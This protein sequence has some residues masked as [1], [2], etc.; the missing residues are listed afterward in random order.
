MRSW[1]RVVATI[2]DIITGA[3]QRYGVDPQALVRIAE[4]ESSLN[5]GARNPNSSAGGLFQ[6]IDS[7]AGQ[8]GLADRFD[9]AQAADAAARLARDNAA[10]L[11]SVLGRD[12]SGAEL[13]LAHQQ[14]LG[15]A[16]KILGNPD[17][18]LASLVGGAAANLNAGAGLTAGQFAQNWASKFGGGSNGTPPSAPG[19]EAGA[20]PGAPAPVAAP[21]PFDPSLLAA[22]FA[23]M[24]APNRQQPDPRHAEQE[25]RRRALLSTIGEMYA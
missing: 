5:P 23:P 19:A 17:A 9:P 15:G 2:A 7:T 4:I 12:P 6:F 24:P 8:Y 22:Q 20:A 11:R 3:A 25:Q 14:G 18:P 13:Y 1:G 16:R 21:E 10:G